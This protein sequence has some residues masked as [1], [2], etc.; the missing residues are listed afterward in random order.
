VLMSEGQ[1]FDDLRVRV[2]KDH[3]RATRIARRY[4]AS[5]DIASYPGPLIGGP[6]IQTNIFDCILRDV[7]HGNQVTPRLS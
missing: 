5:V 4:G 3:N 6:I 7:T 2:A 1:K